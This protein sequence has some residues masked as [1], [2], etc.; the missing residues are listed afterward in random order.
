VNFGAAIRVHQASDII[1]QRYRIERILGQG[2]TGITDEAI[3]LSTGQAVAL[4]VL[5]LRQITDWKIAE[6]TG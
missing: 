4:K 5:S 2:G 3:D 1:A 6:L